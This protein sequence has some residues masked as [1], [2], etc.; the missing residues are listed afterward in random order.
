MRYSYHRPASLDEASDMAAALPNARFIQ[1]G[2]DLMVRIG[3]GRERPGH[4]ISLRRIG[5]LTTIDANREI[6]IGAGATLSDT[7]AHPDIRRRLPALA[8]SL[9]ALG[10]RQVR[11][12]GT[13][14]GNLCNA[15]PAADTAPPLLVYDARVEI[16]NGRAIRCLPLAEFLLGPGKTALQ[17]GEI[18]V[19]IVVPD[20][21]EGTASAFI[22]RGRETMDL[23]IDSVAA[24]VRLNGG[25]SIAIRVAAGAVAPTPRRLTAA[26]AVA[27]PTDDWSRA[28]IAARE[29][30]E[31]ITDLRASAEYRRHLTGILVRRA[32]TMAAAASGQWSID[33]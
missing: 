5:E 31:P 33:R 28:A 19:A 3:Q 15:S 29:Q 24:S 2:T 9:A 8:Q 21:P 25:A 32:L 14:G 18:L 6:R 27:T 7:L 10:S 13:I 22:R 4:L 1:G 11:N 20:P 17:A 30:I 12:M 23:A 26:E 16:R